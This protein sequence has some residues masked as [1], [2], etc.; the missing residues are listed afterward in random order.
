MWVDHELSL[1]ERMG[2]QG[3]AFRTYD[4]YIG[5][6]KGHIGRRFDSL[7]CYTLQT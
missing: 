3:L 5:R 7:E 1:I 2:W 6:F 4:I